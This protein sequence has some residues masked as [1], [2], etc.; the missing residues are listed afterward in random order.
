[1]TTIQRT[2]VEP[3]R[4][5]HVGVVEHRGGVEQH[6]EDEHGERRNA[7]RHHRRDLDRQREQ[8]F[9]RMEAHAGGHVDVEIG[10]M[11]AVQP[12]QHRHVMKDDVLDVDD[13]IEREEAEHDARPPRQA[14]RVNRPQPRSAAISATPTAAVGTSS[15]TARMSTAR[16]P[17]LPGQR[18]VR[19][20]E[21]RPPRGDAIPTAP[22]RAKTTAAPATRTAISRLGDMD[23]CLALVS[24][25]LRPGDL[26]TRSTCQRCRSRA[27]LLSLKNR[28]KGRQPGGRAEGRERNA[29]KSSSSSSSTASRSARSTA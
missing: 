21:K 29:W 4:Q 16:M 7:E 19:P 20:D 8:D 24:L 25:G 12:P 28:N 27:A 23:P 18:G 22:C 1:M 6:L 3:R 9:Q 5:R 11:H 14:G 17:R 10:V 13:E 15:R 26:I 2:T